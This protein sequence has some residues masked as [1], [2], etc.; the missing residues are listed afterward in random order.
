MC[1]DKLVKSDAHKIDSRN[2]VMNYW[3]VIKSKN[4]R[5]IH[6]LYSLFAATQYKILTWMYI[7]NIMNINPNLYY[8]VIFKYKEYLIGYLNKFSPKIIG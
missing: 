7:H 4:G 2:K 5:D 3:F 6:S 1:F 8:L